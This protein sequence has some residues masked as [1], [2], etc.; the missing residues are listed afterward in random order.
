MN[1]L[2]IILL[3][4]FVMSAAAAHGPDGDHGHDD[5]PAAQVPAGAAPRVEA[6]SE[7]F[8][9]VGQLHQ[10]ELSILIDRYE[11]NLPVLD[12]KLEV[13]SSGLKA[14]AKFHA[15]LGDYAVDDQR[16]LAALAKPGK[17]PL[18]FTLTTPDESDL[19]EGTLEMHADAHTG[20]HSRFPWTWAGAGV[21]AALAGIVVARQ[22]R[23]RT[24]STGK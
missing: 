13:E 15:D 16:F 6:S 11:T 5:A 10:D 17:H 14:N 7:S 9:L 23:H 3:Y 2:K 18:V 24:T 19:L 21:L 22:L 8:E 20:D 12:G 4:V 1:I